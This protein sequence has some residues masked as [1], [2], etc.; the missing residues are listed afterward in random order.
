MIRAPG[1]EPSPLSTPIM[2]FLLDLLPVIAF[3]VAYKL[4]DIYVATG[5][6]IVGVLIQTAWSWVRHRKVSPMLLTSAVLVLVFGGL[7]LAI[8]DPTFIKW[9]PSIVNWLFA[10]AFLASQYLSGPTIVQRLMGENVT[11][12]A[13]SWKRLNLAWVA[14]FLVAGT[15]NLYVAFRYDEAT[16]VN[17]KLFGLM[18]LTLVFALAQGVWIARKAEAA[19]A[20]PN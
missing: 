6:L 4:T 5:V 9:K 7:T 16:W 14:F 1:S 15:L 19:D 2:Q 11:L 13:G 10:G 17:F 18:G 3:F 12:D 8:H 20:G